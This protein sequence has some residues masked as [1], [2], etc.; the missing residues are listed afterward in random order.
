MKTKFDT[1]NAVKQIGW[2]YPTSSG[3]AHLGFT[4]SGCYGVAVGKDLQPKKALKGF[5]TWDE[6]KAYAD[7]LPQ[8]FGR[9]TMPKPAHCS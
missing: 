4:A 5:K 6:A 1:K 3:A 9:F 8:P 2:Y 7:T